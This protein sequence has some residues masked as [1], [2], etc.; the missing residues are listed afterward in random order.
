MICAYKAT[1]TKSKVF[2]REYQIDT[3]ISL[4]RLH[5]FL[6]MDLEYSSD[7]MV[8]FEAIDKKG[9]PVK[10]Y[11]LFDFGDGSMDTVTLQMTIDNEELVLR[12]VYNIPMGLSIILTFIKEEEYNRRYSYPCLVNEKGRIPE[13]F[14]AQY[15]EFVEYSEYNRSSYDDS[16]E[17]EEYDEDELPE[18]EENL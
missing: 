13:Q 8:Y 2:M 3:Q 10:R 18:G 6:C 15:E 9:N 12:Y 7:Q 17:Q 14:S 5:E 4:Y 16:E 11:G 1:I